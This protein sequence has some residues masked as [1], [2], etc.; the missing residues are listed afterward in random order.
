MGGIS[1]GWNNMLSIS[2]ETDKI[3]VYQTKS[4]LK[5]LV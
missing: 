1:S 5:H 4:F 2:A 3:I